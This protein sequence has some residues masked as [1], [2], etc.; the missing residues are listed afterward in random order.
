MEKHQQR[1]VKKTPHDMENGTINW[2]EKWL[3][4]NISS[5]LEGG[6]KLESRF[7]VP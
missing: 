1:V 4:K 5:G 3:T 6:F 7:K 2:A